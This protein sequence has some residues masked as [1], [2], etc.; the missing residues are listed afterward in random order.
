MLYLKFSRSIFTIELIFSAFAMPS[1]YLSTHYDQCRKWTQ[2]TQTP[3]HIITNWWPLHLADLRNSRSS[4][5]CCYQSIRVQLLS[6]RRTFLEAQAFSTRNQLI[7]I[8][9]QGIGNTY[10][11]ALCSLLKYR[12]IKHWSYAR[13][14]LSRMGSTI[15]LKFY[16]TLLNQKKSQIMD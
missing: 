11:Y 15:F 8:N 2:F 16:S 4:A 9:Q 13:N 14:I 7:I 12:K 6:Q 3:I 10:F 5:T 1:T